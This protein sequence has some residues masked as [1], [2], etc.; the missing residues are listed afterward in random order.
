MA[1]CANCGRELQPAWKA[2]VLG[3]AWLVALVVLV[4]AFVT[5]NA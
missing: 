1:T 2:V 3:Y 5:T 4:I